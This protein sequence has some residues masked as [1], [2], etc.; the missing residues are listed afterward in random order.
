MAIGDVIITSLGDIVALVVNFVVRLF[1]LPEIQSQKIVFFVQYLLGILLAT[2]LI[3]I[4]FKY[5]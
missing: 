4:T 1:G 2:A 5:S 3:Y